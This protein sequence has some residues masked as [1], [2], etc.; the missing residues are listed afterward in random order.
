MSYIVLFE[1]YS[2]FRQY[3]GEFREKS[4]NLKIDFIRAVHR[5]YHRKTRLFLIM[6]ISI[7]YVN[8]Y[9]RTHTRARPIRVPIPLPT[10]IFIPTHTH[11]Y[12]VGSL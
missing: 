8:S 11:P 5:R 6:I 4:I 12:I 3:L 10:L 9:I 7:Y 2:I 1:R